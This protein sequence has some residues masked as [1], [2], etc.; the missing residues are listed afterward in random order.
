MYIHTHRTVPNFMSSSSLRFHPRRV[1]LNWLN[2][3]LQLSITRF[4]E[5]GTGAVYFQLLDVM[6]PGRIPMKRVNWADASVISKYDRDT[7]LELLQKLFSGLPIS[8]AF[9]LPQPLSANDHFETCQLFRAYW[10]KVG[11]RISDSY[12]PELRRRMSERTPAKLFAPWSDGAHTKKGKP[13][14]FSSW[15]AFKLE[16]AKRL[17]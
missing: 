3:L 17:N 4:E 1:L 14:L 2:D 5:L 13:K 7:Q 15:L 9:R 8:R 6:Y 11:F 10:D 16:F 12:S